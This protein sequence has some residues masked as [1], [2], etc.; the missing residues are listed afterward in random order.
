MSLRLPRRPGEASV[1]KRARQM[2]SVWRGHFHRRRRRCTQRI[3]DCGESDAGGSAH[4]FGTAATGGTAHTRAG[5]NSGC[6]PRATAA[7]TG[8]GPGAASATAGASCSCTRTCT[9]TAAASCRRTTAGTRRT[10]NASRIAAEHSGAGYGAAAGSRSATDADSAGRTTDAIRAPFLGDTAGKAVDHVAGRAL[11]ASALRR[12]AATRRTAPDVDP[13]CIAS[14]AATPRSP[15]GGSQCIATSVGACVSPH[16]GPGGASA[17]RPTTGAVSADAR[18]GNGRCADAAC[19]DQ[20]LSRQRPECEG[21]AAG[22]GAR[23]GYL[24]L[25]PTEARG[26]DSRRHAEAAFSRGNQEELRGIRRPDRPGVRRVH[27]SLPGCAERRPGWGKEALLDAG[28][29]GY[30]PVS[31]LTPCEPSAFKPDGSF[32][33]RENVMAENERTRLLSSY[34]DQLAELRRYL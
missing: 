34:D 25:F 24:R 32:L 11:C 3:R 7:G 17:S 33:T 6:G 23:V 5:T 13:S 31:I 27:V 30:L 4:G 1:G 28:P 2:L 22:S 19:A 8:C 26:R 16:N 9:P 15:A 29:A 10:T 20:S 12:D 18:A 21:E 14:A